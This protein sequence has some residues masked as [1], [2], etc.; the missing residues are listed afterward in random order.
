MNTAPLNND[1]VTTSSGSANERIEQFT[2]TGPVRG[3]IRCASGRA[4]VTN[5]PDGACRVRAIAL[6]SHGPDRLAQVEI[7]FDEATNTLRVLTRP[8]GSFRVRLFDFHDVE[9]EI[10]VPAS[11][12]IDI[13]SASGDLRLDGTFADVT[14]A[15]ASGDVKVGTITGEFNVNVASG[16]VSATAVGGP[17]NAKSASGDVKLGDV[18]SD[19]KVHAVSGDIALNAV[20]SLDAKLHSVSGDVLINVR[21]GFVVHVNAKTVS[22]SMRSEISLDG[23]E[24]SSS[25]AASEGV[26]SI[27]ASTVSGDVKIARS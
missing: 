22:G 18:S 26:I 7:S 8:K 10:M 24:S 4:T 17:V 6:G 14:A 27:D 20:G 5:G 3:T 21:P 12:N 23:T 13:H 11:S 16:D 1:E 19:V 25:D 9:L 2:T 15:S